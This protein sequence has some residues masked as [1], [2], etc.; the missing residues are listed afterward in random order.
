MSFVMMVAIVTQYP[1]ESVRI[2][3]F[4][5][6]DAG[7]ISELFKQV[8]PLLT[9]YPEAW[10]RKRCYSPEK[11]VREM[12]NGYHY[13]GARLRGRIVGVYKA[14]VTK[15]GLYG[16]HQTVVPSC[17][18]SGL[19]SAMYIQF[20]EYGRARG[21]RRNYCNILVGSEIGEHLM[22]KFGFRPWGKPYYQDKDLLVQ[23]YE[24]L[25]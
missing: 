15:K 3:E 5:K 8:W 19:A 24:R 20:A 23:M 11:I 12:H 10:R 4:S 6:Q 18:D 14:R 2:M 1:E 9:E 25:L 17:R 22:Q 13:F 21:C 16:E 7:E